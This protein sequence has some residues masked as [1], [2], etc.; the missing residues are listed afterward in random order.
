MNRCRY[1]IFILFTVL[2][3]S[4]KAQNALK[5]QSHSIYLYEPDSI[6]YDTLSGTFFYENMIDSYIEND[7]VVKPP[8]FI[9][10]DSISKFEYRNGYYINDWAYLKQLQRKGMEL[11]FDKK[12][13]ANF[14]DSLQQR[15]LRNGTYMSETKINPFCGAYY[16]KYV[17]KIEILYIDTVLQRTPLFMDCPGYK[18]YVNDNHKNYEMST[19]PTYVITRII[20]WKEL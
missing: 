11:N 7:A 20:S 14:Y 1:Q 6:K 19:L 10:G 8:G 16:K 2:L 3:I 15:L 9:H 18:M 4:C 5:S 13:I 17:M 12:S